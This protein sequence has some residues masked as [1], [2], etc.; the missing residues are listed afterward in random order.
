VKFDSR[1]TA[2]L[3]VAELQWQ[4]GKT[5]VVWPA[6]RKTGSFLFPVPAS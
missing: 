1:N 6:D 4:N 5:V 2:T 3:Q